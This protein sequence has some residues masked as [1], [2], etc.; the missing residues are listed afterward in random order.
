MGAR[1]TLTDAWPLFGLR[2][3][4]DRLVLRLPGD[5]DLVRLL[6]LAREGIHEPGTMPFGVAWSTLPSPAFD[7]GFMQHHWG[8]RGTWSPDR[9]FLNLIVEWHGD[10]IGSQSIDAADFAAERT[11]HTG[12]WLGRA[13][14]GRGFG[15][16]MRAAVLGF[17]FDGLGARLALTEAFLDNAASNGVSRS[18]GYEPS[19]FGS[20]A[21]EGVARTTQLFRMTADGWRSRPRPALT[22]EGLEGCRDM[23]GA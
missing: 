6:T 16:E 2:L 17:G 23:F 5:G 9:W 18:L 11:I 14:Q 10:A 15:K 21:P 3:R 8:T 20:L 1:T 7:R 22:I 13:F 4:T 19:G 12:S